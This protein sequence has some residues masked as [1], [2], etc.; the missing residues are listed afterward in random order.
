LL[1][2][3][4][5]E[6]RCA[7]LVR[8]PSAVFPRGYLWLVP[9]WY[10]VL[11]A[12]AYDTGRLPSWYEVC[13]IGPT[14]LA[15]L[16]VITVLA[17]LRSNAF[18]A[19]ESGILLGLRGAAQRRIGRRRRQKHLVWYEVS[20][21][22]IA[23]RPYGARLDVLMAPGSPTGNGRLVWRI[24]AAV[25]TVLLPPACMF[26]SPGLLRPRS[27]SGRV[28]Y[29]VPLYDVRPEQLQ[30]A[31]APLAP[32]GVAISVRP[33]WRARALARLRRLRRSRLTTAA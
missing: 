16:I 28:R 30:L 32:R 22:R 19:D 5:V 31:L 13:C 20:Q 12:L 4:V 27:R 15:L 7:A 24:I 1:V 26:R 17:T 8:G 14:F 3:A 21:L 18:V 25:V 6:N 23:Y 9:L 33:R 29:R 2:E 11:V 10:L